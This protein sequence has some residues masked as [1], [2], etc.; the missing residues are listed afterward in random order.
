ML[1]TAQK[2]ARI[3]WNAKP[4]YYIYKIPPLVPL[5]IHITP[6]HALS[7]YFFKFTSILSFYQRLS[8]P[9][10]LLNQVRISLFCHA[11]YLRCSSHPRGCDSPN[12]IWWAAQIM[13]LFIKR[14]SQASHHLL[15]V[16][17]NF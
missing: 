6:V 12:N 9:D 17:P 5:L 2:T 1:S 4:Y 11:C 14:F 8:F 10:N 13:K 3:S 15:P 16:M 7:S